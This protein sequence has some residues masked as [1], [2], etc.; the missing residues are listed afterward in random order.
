MRPLHEAATTRDSDNLDTR[1]GRVVGWLWLVGIASITTGCA[2]G[3]SEVGRRGTGLTSVAVGGLSSGQA[4]VDVTNEAAVS[5]TTVAAPLTTVWRLMPAVLEQLQVEV[6]YVDPTSGTIGN[7]SFRARR[8][9]GRALST[10]LDCGAGLTRA[11]AD[12]YEVRM[13]ILVQLI[14]AAGGGTVVRT[15]VDAYAEDRAVASRPIH[16]QSRGVLERRIWALVGERLA[17]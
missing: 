10:Y 4:T 2:S 16:C 5:E 1:P 3:G 11:Y 8:I 9:E 7:G 13:S 6:D 14:P 12:A 17:A 15:A